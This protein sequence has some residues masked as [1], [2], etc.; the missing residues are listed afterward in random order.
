MCLYPA[1]GAL[2][3]WA[4]PA[5]AEPNFAQDF[6]Q[7]QTTD[8]IDDDTALAKRMLEAARDPQADAAQVRTL[9]PMIVELTQNDRDSYTMAIEAL[10][11]LSRRD[12]LETTAAL[13]RGID[14]ADRM[15]NRS[16]G[17]QRV[18]AGRVLL[19]AMLSLADTYLTEG[20][21][22]NAVAYYQ[23]AAAQAAQMKSDDAEAIGRR[24]KQIESRQRLVELKRQFDS[25]RSDPKVAEQLMRVHLLELDDP[26]GAWSY[27]LHVEDGEIKRHAEL[28]SRNLESLTAAEAMK[29]GRWYA[30]QLAGAPASNR[31]AIRQ[32][33]AACFGRVKRIAHAGEQT[34]QAAAEALAKL[35]TANLSDTA[36]AEKPTD[37]DNMPTPT[38]QP[39]DPERSWDQLLSKNLAELAQQNKAK[40]DAGVLTFDA[41]QVR[42]RF[43]EPA[44]VTLTRKFLR[45]YECVLEVQ[46]NQAE[47]TFGVTLPVHDRAMHVTLAGTANTVG[48]ASLAEQLELKSNRRYK[49]YISVLVLND[50]VDLELKL[51][52]EKT[53]RWSGDAWEIEQMPEAEGLGLYAGGTVMHAY[54][55][56]L[57]PLTA[58]EAA[59]IRENRRLAGTGTGDEDA[60]KFFGIKS[61]A[62]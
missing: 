61:S 48:G 17:E 54:R 18:Q 16:I 25:N 62:K 45:S 6:E 37:N 13:Q 10:R 20:D 23:L 30:D 44:E 41:S 58:I 5:G 34:R 27:W 46:Y 53:Y 9:T 38:A 24:L 28:A 31:L 47:G 14:I 4:A 39:K 26:E 51:D 21:L 12:A 2:L 50:K 60:V 40:L 15:Y 59:T 8:T 7:V 35:D 22:D 57:K 19:D 33:A 56:D 11:M 43:A 32:R 3:L 55:A 49:L 42:G 29:L 36:V 52:D 1:I